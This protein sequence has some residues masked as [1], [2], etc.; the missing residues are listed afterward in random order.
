MTDQPAQ[1]TPEE[2]A[3]LEFLRQNT[4]EN[5]AVLHPRIDSPPELAYFSVSPI[6]GRIIK[7]SD[8]ELVEKMRVLKFIESYIAIEDGVPLNQVTEQYIDKILS[9][10]KAAEAKAKTVQPRPGI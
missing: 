5:I 2:L 1:L 8:P 6:E 9:D 10:A 4:A 7:M 3:V